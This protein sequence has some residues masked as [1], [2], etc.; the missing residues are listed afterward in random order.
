MTL[1]LLDTVAVGR[2]KTHADVTLVPLYFTP[3][4]GL[5]KVGSV[6]DLIVTEVP[7]GE[8][9]LAE[10]FNPTSTPILLPQGY[11]LTG[12]RQHRV[13]VGSV[14]VGAGSRLEVETA[15]VQRGRWS[16]DDNFLS[17][18]LFAPPSVRRAALGDE[19]RPDD[20]H[21]WDFLRRFR[22]RH[23]PWGGGYSPWLDYPYG[24]S[25][26]VSF[27]H[28]DGPPP[29]WNWPWET[30][31]DVQEAV[32]D[33]VSASLRAVGR[34]SDTSDLLEAFEEAD[35]SAEHRRVVD[36]VVARGPRPGQTGLLV[37]HGRQ[38]VGFEL[39][40]S[41][42]LLAEHWEG[43]VRSHFLVRPSRAEGVV[44][45]DK[46]LRFVGGFMSKVQ[47]TVPTQG[48]GTCNAV[49]S[50]NHFGRVL[51]LDDTVIHAVGFRR[52]IRA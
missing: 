13:V 43:I 34:D 8:V 52:Q 33:E 14:L 35:Q 28:P 41:P 29:R 49:S 31:R 4:P 39:F 50:K 1:D 27:P 2:P 5:P 48:L 40:Q 16:G 25:R 45:A 15:C 22:V 3:P 38:I 9:E 20:V 47:R 11:L 7:G 6:R 51:V 17:S 37:S 26:S 30:E 46:V 32:W 21:S 18:R 10:V 23:E 24:G 44:S 12:G 36:E 19:Q 42:E